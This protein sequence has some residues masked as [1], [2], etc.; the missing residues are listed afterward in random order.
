MNFHK[1]T[2]GTI[3]GIAVKIN[4][5]ITTGIC[6]FGAWIR[7]QRSIQP[8]VQWNLFFLKITQEYWRRLHLN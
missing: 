1:T 4:T 3:T 6:T 8:Q 2:A 5:G 7:V